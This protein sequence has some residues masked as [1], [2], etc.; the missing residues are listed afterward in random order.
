[1]EKMNMI[2]L[3]RSILI[4]LPKEYRNNVWAES[5]GKI[6]HEL[7][8]ADLEKEEIV[9]DASKCVWA[10][11][12]PLLSLIICLAEINNKRI[13]KK[14]F[15]P[16]IF[17]AQIEQKG[18]LAYLNKEGFLDNIISH[19]IKLLVSTENG[20][21]ESFDHD[22]HGKFI[23]EYEKYL[24]YYDCSILRAHVIDLSSPSIQNIGIEQYIDN[25]LREIRHRFRYKIQASN[26]KETFNKI[27]LF[28][29]ETIENVFEHAYVKTERKLVGYYVRYRQ[30]LADNSLDPI[31]RQKLSATIDSE[32]N[33]SPRLQK[34]FLDNIPSFIE[35]FVVD[36]GMGLTKNYFKDRE[37]KH[38]LFRE[39]WRDT[40][41]MGLRGVKSPKKNTEFGGLYTLNRL[42]LH[43]YL[44]A[45]DENE[46][47]GDLL[48]VEGR[49]MDYDANKSYLQIIS[50]QQIDGLALIGRISWKSIT[51][52]NKSWLKLWNA[53]GL[54]LEH[55]IENPF[56]RALKE[57]KDIYLKYYGRHFDEIEKK[58]IYVIDDRIHIEDRKL[59]ESYLAHRDNCEFFLLLPPERLS[60]NKLFRMISDKIHDV[61]ISHKSLIIADIAVW[62]ASIYQLA[63]EN[64]IYENKF[65]EKIE[66][67]VLITRRLTI[68]ILSKYKSTY[69]F[70]EHLT[71]NFFFNIPKDFL[72]DCSFSHFVEL[73]RTHDSMI[74]WQ[75]IKRVNR[76]GEFYINKD[77]AWY[78]DSIDIGLRGYLD[79]S[80]T[81]TDKFCT[82]LYEFSLERT[83]CLSNEHGCT[84]KSIDVLT[85]KLAMQYNSLFYNKKSENSQNILLGSVFV[86]GFSEKASEIGQITRFSNFKIHFFH[87]QYI[88][89]NIEISNVP[90]LLLWPLKGKNWFKENLE[91]QEDSIFLTSYR[92]VGTSYVIAPFG[93]KY[94]PI[95]R[96]KLFDL[97]LKKFLNEYTIEHLNNP[98]FEFKS[99]YKCSPPETY[100]DWQGKRT[101]VL[102]LGHISY[103]STHDLFNIDFPFVI[104]ESFMIGGKLSQFLVA[105]FLTALGC[106]EKDIIELG[107]EK[108]ISGVK[109]Y[110]QK[111]YTEQNI[112]SI[113]SA[114]IV[115]PFH[116]NSDY[117]VSIIK[118]HINP[119]LHER[120]IALFPLN[121]E[122]AETT[123]LTSPLTIESIRKK[124]KEFKEKNP[125]KEINILLFDDATIGGKTRTE[126]K[127]ILF[128][129]GANNIRTIT[130]LERR[131]L[132]FNT[133]DP[134]YNKA[135]WRLDIPKLGNADT[136][137]I[138]NAIKSLQNVESI[139]ASNNI[140]LQINKIIDNWKEITPFEHRENQ[141]I[142]PIRIDDNGKSL[143][144]KFSIYF[145]GY[146]HEQCGGERN[147]I[148]ITNSLGLSLY[149]SEL[150]SMTSRDDIVFQ[151]LDGIEINESAKIQVLST[152]LLLFGKELSNITR[153]KIITL[154]FN[155]SNSTE[156]NIHTSFALI[157]LLSQGQQRL[158]FLY[159]IC[160]DEG[161]SDIK[162]GNLDM[163]ILC[164][165]LSIDN[166]SKFS[167]SNYLKRL[168]KGYKNLKDLYKQLH[169]EIFN[170][171]GIPHD[172][173]LQLI[174]KKEYS[175]SLIR[176]AEDICD[177]LIFLM[178]K[179]P[180][181]YYR[182]YGN[183]EI[184]KKIE[185]LKIY[186]LRYKE[187]SLTITSI[188]NQE[189]LTLIN[190]FAKDIFNGFIPI[191][192]TLFI[193]IGLRSDKF[194]L[195]DRMQSLISEFKYDIGLSNN[196]K[197]LP[198]N[199]ENLQLE[200]WIAWD[201]NVERKIGFLLKNAE[202]GGASA[203]IGDPFISNSELK[204][205]WI[206]IEY[207]ELEN[208]LELYIFNKSELTSNE[209]TERT[210]LKIKPEKLHLKELE[211][212][213]VYDDVLYNNEL[214]L[215][216]II[217][218]P[219]I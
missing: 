195:K 202:K 130:I 66:K 211:I 15:L 97:K 215:K 193:S 124:I 102:S 9:V 186:V 122:R 75:N 26:E 5:F 58:P 49:N 153:E 207:F 32:H 56:I 217:S 152:Y 128:Y 192:E 147:W 142:T 46:W 10:D 110:L 121:K 157:A 219:Y 203:K 194:P 208:R 20:E 114:V 19:N 187:A 180:G 148:E 131:R 4:Q 135:Y 189:Q 54:N 154:L 191:H 81:L 16:K 100:S 141:L 78:Q 50:D 115:Y 93:W 198:L 37:E 163:Q 140:L 137:P 94:F 90:Q 218:F 129:L 33:N 80:K 89:T 119:E 170:D 52:E 177:K 133:S 166:K 174:G 113:E 197:K 161:E 144:K 171:Y 169:S 53:P 96:Y 13:V 38:P 48:P 1:M 45:R 104:N 29:K 86:S 107:N 39:A 28:L 181:W 21:E 168:K 14:I 41:G 138:C 204:N 160:K 69:K 92:R 6:Q 109:D 79:F 164:L 156:S 47:L 206:S 7:R 199:D 77:I 167:N 172:T 200:R 2:T 112:K 8:K 185:E 132:P 190:R 67:I 64:A 158:E 55:S 116:Y 101:Q 213:I 70:D 34:W 40:I 63:L 17:D 88:K 95:P 111:E 139:I 126:I 83:L 125:Q 18:F 27:A 60:K 76:Y 205:A 151:Y 120:I 68:C 127:H 178:N 73:I 118:D 108:L 44:V 65:L 11:P 196:F 43:N 23:V 51:D 212:S 176:E 175:L 210:K 25:Q 85:N 61:S 159:D 143:S 214:L 99:I 182:V 91:K 146:K 188:D 216:T 62:E 179:I 105:E 155:L 145:N 209:V 149:V 134:R 184:H 42:C 22:T 82:K 84:Y 162:L 74:F 87:N 12:L 136:C 165:I 35:I 36:A 150:H 183:N 59:K 30:G 98:N 57:P 72:P 31:S 123:F 173:A 117:V 24:S 201:R 103:E 71:N 106:D 3:S